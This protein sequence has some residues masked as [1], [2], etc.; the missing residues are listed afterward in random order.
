MFFLHEF[1]LIIDMFPLFLE[2]NRATFPPETEPTF[3]YRQTYTHKERTHKGEM[4]TGGG[5]TQT[6][7]EGHTH[8]G[9]PTNGYTHGGGHTHGQTYTRNKHTHGGT[10]TRRNTHERTYIRRKIHTRGTYTRRD[11]HTG[12]TYTSIRGRWR[13]NSD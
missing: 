10:H 4:H 5:G 3:Q 8:G 13:S 7:T 9:T 11:I 1:F 2:N 12:G 6:H